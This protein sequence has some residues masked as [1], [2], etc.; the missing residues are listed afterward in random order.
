[1][2]Q[3]NLV[4]VWLSIF[5]LLLV[6]IVSLESSAYSNNGSQ[7]E[8]VD[9]QFIRDFADNLEAQIDSYLLAHQTSTLSDLQHDVV[10]ESI[11]V[12]QV[13]D[14]GYTG[15]M[16]SETGF[17]YF[18]PRQELI[19]TD[20]HSFQTT[21]PDFWNIFNE[22]MNNGNC[23]DSSGYYMWKESDGTIS[24]KYMVT[25][26]IKISTADNKKLFL[27]VT[28]YL[29]EANATKYIKK[30]NVGNS[31][32][33]AKSAIRQKAKDVA[34]QIEIY[35]KSNPEK[36]VS[37]LQKDL[38]FREIAVQPVGLTGY[39]A[40]TDSK[41][42]I[43]RFH[44]NEK[45]ID[46]DLSTLSEIHPAFWNI[47][48]ES[49]KGFESEGIYNWTE[50]DG[51]VEQKYMYVA[52]VHAK[53]A[54]NVIFSV[55]ATTYL[56]EYDISSIIEK[57]NEGK[58]SE[59]EIN[60]FEG[61][62]MLWILFIL[63]TLFNLFVIASKSEKS[64]KKFRF[65]Y[66]L[67]SLFSSLF[68][69][70]YFIETF[71]MSYFPWLALLFERI[72]LVFIFSMLLVFIFL[73]YEIV[74]YELNK[75]L[76]YFSI[77]FQGILLSF[78][79]FSSSFIKGATLENSFSY[80]V[81]GNLFSLLFLLFIHDVFLLLLPFV[82]KD[83]IKKFDL[84]RKIVIISF[85]IFV[86]IAMISNGLVYF[87]FKIQNPLFN[88]GS[89]VLFNV[90]VW[91]FL[92]Y[93][94]KINLEKISLVILMI[95]IMLL[96]S[97]LII[98]NAFYISQEL[99]SEITASF[100]EDQNVNLEFKDAQLKS[101]FSSLEKDLAY[102]AKNLQLTHVSESHVSRMLRSSFE[103]EK[104]FVTSA[105]VIDDKG[106]IGAIYPEDQSV[107]GVNISNQKHVQTISSELI[108]VVSN[109]F[110]AVQNFSAI[111][112]D[113]PFFLNNSYGGFVQYFI[114][115]N[116]LFK[117]LNINSNLTNF[118]LLD[119]NNI[120]LYSSN[121]SAIGKSFENL[122]EEQSISESYILSQIDSVDSK[123]ETVN[124]QLE[125]S[126]KFMFIKPFKITNKYWVLVAITDVSSLDSKIIGK[127]KQIFI[128]TII[129]IIS[130]IFL[131]FLFFNILTKNL[132][133]EI[134]LKTKELRTL[135]NSLE[136]EVKLRTKEVQKKAHQLQLLNKNLEIQVKH[137]TLA[138]QEKVERGNKTRLAMIHILKDYKK[139]NLELKNKE[140]EAER[141][142]VELRKLNRE[143]DKWSKTLEQK[144]RTRTA[145][146][147]RANIK[148]TALLKIKTEFL[149]QV[150]HD[151][152]T[153]LT[154]IK[155]LLPEVQK[156]KKLT[157]KSKEH[158]SVI[159]RN[160]D[161]LL[162]L[163][164]N[165]LNL[166]RLDSGK[167]P[168]EV[169]KVN[170]YELIS[171]FI[172]ENNA[173]FKHENIKIINTI[174]KD[175]GYAYLDRN[176]ILEVIGNLVSNAQKYFDKNNKQILFEAKKKGKNIEM[177][178]TDNGRGIS[179]ENITKIFDEFFKVDQYQGGTSPG[180]GLSICKKAVEQ[181]KG[182]LW[183]ESEGLG[184]GTTMVL[185]LPISALKS[186]QHKKIT[187]K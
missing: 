66:K 27:G 182:K 185:V 23:K 138:L 37:D 146:L 171:K 10:F 64:S 108:P 5:I 39:T 80:F 73:F 149:N 72:E 161:S 105:T 107:I 121:S 74:G 177:R 83:L 130:M 31:F 84:Q 11:A 44:K 26:C 41:T 51:I 179:K 13:G 173:T 148:V 127:T 125:N 38:Y 45:I 136:K 116:Y 152:R 111:V 81:S 184:K 7:G 176:K 167:H 174:K 180:L 169:E 2:K 69:I 178:I 163:V 150:S 131:G 61:K 93:L 102:W 106:I 60:L 170:I 172:E 104:E 63:L 95:L 151:L 98:F 118:L 135:N 155:L 20:S 48:K 86:A 58:K 25:R 94:K 147:K 28:S 79:L 143:K 35:L 99:R 49:K 16:D 29:D 103:R 91:F 33:F 82:K 159:K 76:F 122:L 19:N 9:E 114:N 67:Y 89:I 162:Y 97:G 4:L 156:D 3:N 22:T 57:K 87:I 186:L 14:Q 18:H 56:D 142:N 187:I 164:T 92:L 119:E 120:I 115:L 137:K 109:S 90:F 70:A 132:R 30:Y 53:T 52:L 34:K 78:L 129:L 15:I 133:E 183:A 50:I 123:Q 165:V 54:D 32:N 181:H 12:Q 88:F 36:T 134:E 112:Y 62:I 100:I 126:S 71:F 101:L 157:K 113:Y 75:K 68:F 17:I 6:Q 117:N 96:F 77:L 46:L 124:L 1:M 59:T 110:L 139:I 55:A 65:Q 8:F 128:S 153:P 145:D 158:L 175:I 154:P 24:K 40:V 160:V 140:R 47:I 43:C 144:V 166:V 141:I 42:L 85:V 168:L 21:L